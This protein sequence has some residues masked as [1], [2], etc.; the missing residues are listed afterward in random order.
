MALESAFSMS[1]CSFHVPKAIKFERETLSFHQN[2]TSGP[3]GIA[4]EGEVQNLRISTDV[5]RVF[6]NEKVEIQAHN[7]GRVITAIRLS[8]SVREDKQEISGGQKKAIVDSSK[9]VEKLKSLGKE[10]QLVQYKKAWSWQKSIVNE[11]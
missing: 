3:K 6:K 10:D 5:K 11:N 4:G 9:A 1:L 2:I 8:G 7:G